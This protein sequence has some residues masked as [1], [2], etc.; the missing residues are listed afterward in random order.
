MSERLKDKVAI[1]TGA[2][3]AGPGWGN[4]KAVAA[5]FARQGAKVLAVDLR[6]EAAAQTCRIIEEEG[7]TAA[8]CQADVSQADQVERMVQRC[9]DLYGRVDIL[10]NNV[11][12][13]ELGGT[14]ETS[15]ESW[16]R[17]MDVNLKSMFLTCRA[18]LP[19]ME[20]QGGGAIVNISSVAGIRHLGIPYLSYST[21]KAAI[22][23]LTQ[24]IAVEYA[25]KNIRANA[26][27][28]GLMHT[29]L[30]EGLARQVYG[31]DTE[32]MLE[33]RSQQAPM[34][35][36]GDAW[37]V[38]YAAL[39]LASDEAKYITGIQL[40]VDGGLTCKVN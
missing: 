2:G 15:E 24:S 10:H 35:R 33:I 26:I 38:A 17:V 36:M 32:M 37:D 22:L 29:P 12:I 5:L 16:D 27:L 28:P 40:V 19:H 8:P 3:A 7:H 31:T 25:A 39:F 20:R 23:Q 4:G 9:L 14:A 34:K 6:A 18:A 1:V 13:I 21:T 30:I 11:G